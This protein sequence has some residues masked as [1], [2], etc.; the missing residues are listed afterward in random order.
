[1]SKPSA[2]FTFDTEFLADG[3]RAAP[4]ARA[5]QRRT[6]T[7][8]ELETMTAD[9][10]QEGENAA[11]VRASQQV[12]RAIAALTISLRAALDTSHAEIETLRA[13]AAVM[14]LAMARKIAPA[15]IAICPAADVA[16]AL[17]QAMHPAIIEPRI[18]L[19]A[20]PAVMA[21]L[22]PAIAAIAHEEGYDGRV[23][24][25]PDPAF[26]GADC[27]IDWRGGG[28]ERSQSAIEAALADL[29]ETFSAHHTM[30]GAAGSNTTVKG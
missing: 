7:V 21:L 2:K 28:T 6:L 15:A 22:E 24:L 18:T 17:R 26:S 12:E 8:E 9:A 30:P 4:A 11:G 29:I 10:R 16:R 13:E 19:R 20:A 5:R 25:S 1:M 23:M 3:D 27:R 14:A